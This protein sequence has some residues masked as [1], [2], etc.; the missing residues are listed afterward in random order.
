MFIETFGKPTVGILP[1]QHENYESQN[2]SIQY[3]ASKHCVRITGRQDTG[4]GIG[5]W[6]YDK[7]SQGDLIGGNCWLANYQGRPMSAWSWA[8]P[9]MLS[10]GGGGRSSRSTQTAETTANTGRPQG[11]STSFVGDYQ[12]V[13][14]GKGGAPDVKRFIPKNV[15]VPAG[16]GAA[17][18]DPNGPNENPPAGPVDPN[19]LILGIGG[20]VISVTGGSF[21]TFD[22]VRTDFSGASFPEFQGVRTNFSG[23][24]PGANFSGVKDNFS[25]GRS[26]NRPK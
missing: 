2:F 4:Q 18:N 1:L 9:A 13:P 11:V 14:I 17:G 5:Q 12:A 22:G 25:L 6:T 16:F 8:W 20:Q 10:A 23:G 3:R 15:V 21:P 7:D 24:K 26:G 19:S